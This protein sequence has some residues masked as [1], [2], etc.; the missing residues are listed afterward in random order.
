MVNEAK[1]IFKINLCKVNVIIYEFNVFQCND[2]YLYL[3]CGVSL[4][5]KPFL[6]K[7][8]YLCFFTV[9]CKHGHEVA[10]VEFVDIVVWGYGSTTIEY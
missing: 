5:S 10:S 1:S 3:S 2:D 8:W 6:A 7:V 4:W 9:A